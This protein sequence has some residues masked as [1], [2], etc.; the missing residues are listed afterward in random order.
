MVAISVT[1]S[2]STAA[3]TGGIDGAERKVVVLRDELGD[4]DQVT[5]VDW[6]EGEVARREVTTEPDLWLP[7]QLVDLR[8]DDLLD[9]LRDI[10]VTTPTSSRG[11]EAA[12][13]ARSE[14]SLQRI[15]SGIKE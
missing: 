2:R 11:I 15:A 6:L 10:A 8:A 1:W 5:G 3:T 12:T 9:P 14:V 4:S 13:L 7:T